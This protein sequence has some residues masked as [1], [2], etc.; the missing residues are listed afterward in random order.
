MAITSWWE[1]SRIPIINNKRRPLMIFCI[2]WLK[3]V[4]KSSFLTKA[5]V[6]K[7]SKREIQSK[8]KSK[9]MTSIVMATTLMFRT[10]MMTSSRRLRKANQLLAQ[11]SKRRWRKSRSLDKKS[12]RR[13]VEF[14][15]RNYLSNSKS[16]RK[17]LIKLR[18]NLRRRP[19]KEK[20]FRKSSKRWSRSL[21]L[22]VMLL[23]KKRKPRHMSRDCFN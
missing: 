17:S 1:R 22:V 2:N 13:V 10:L 12:W 18:I 3:K 5:L 8:R 9:M 16:S 21:S 7:N 14:Q 20:I 23:K 6:L 15:P 4:R 19:S 11:R